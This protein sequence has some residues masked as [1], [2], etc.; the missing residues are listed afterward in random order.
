MQMLCFRDTAQLL[1]VDIFRI[2]I[3]NERPNLN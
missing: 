1:Q 2:L 3:L